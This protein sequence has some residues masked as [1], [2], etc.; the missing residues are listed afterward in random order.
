MFVYHVINKAGIPLFR[1]PCENKSEVLKVDE[2]LF[3]GLITALNSF[4]MEATG[5]NINNIN[6]GPITAYF[7][8]DEIGKLHV[9]IVEKHVPDDI[10]R[11]IHY[12]VMN[13]YRR[14]NEKSSIPGQVEFQFSEIH[15]KSVF[16]PFY[17]SWVKKIENTIMINN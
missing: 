13:L 2:V 10:S 1:I 14:I 11:Q 8:K 16:D 9:L 6:F 4:S 15:L 3:S 7:N 17:R 5:N 12:E